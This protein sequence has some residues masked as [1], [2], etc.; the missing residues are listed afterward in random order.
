MPNMWLIYALTSGLLY[1]GSNL[2][3]RHILKKEKNDAWV[4]SFY[5]SAVGALV[6]LPFMLINIKIPSNTSSWLLM[7]VVGILIVIQNLFNFASS[8]YLTPS[9]NGSITKFRLV[10]VMILGIIILGES[11]SALKIIGTFL[12]IASGIIVMK[13]FSKPK[14]LRGVF[15]AFVATIFY[16]VVITLYKF[17]FS[18]FNSQSLTFFIFFIP[19][20][21]NLIIMPNSIKRITKLATTDFKL[22][23][24]GCFLGGLANLAMNEGLLL[25]E[26]SKV[27]VLIESFLI[28]ALIGEHILLREKD[29]LITK[30]VAVILA[31]AGA[32]LI[33]LS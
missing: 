20:I 29:Y 24:I 16:A 17:L 28:I 18:S 9:I 11:S 5:F 31:T 7:L 12:T 8:K 3:T 22:V 30:I 4:F 10:W 6:A 26:A 33:R 27:L 2:I 15:Y 19:M 13:K 32:I 23:F 1:T 21:I 25:G 14:D